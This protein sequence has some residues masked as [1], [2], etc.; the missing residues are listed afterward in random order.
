MAQTPPP[1]VTPAPGVP[2]RGTSTFKAL[3]DAFL[4]W[5]AM[6]VLQLSDL[7]LNVYNNAL[8][9]YNNAVA[10]AASAA[11]AAAIAGAT[12]WVS[13][14]PYASGVCKFS[15]LTFKT[16]RSRAAVTSAVDPSAD[17]ANWELL[18][19]GTL[20][21]LHVRNQQPSGSP[22]S[23]GS[24]IG[25]TQRTLNTVVA[26]TVTGASLASSNVTLP[27]G[28]YECRGITLGY[29]Q[30][31]HKGSLYNSTDGTTVVI[32]S[33]EY[34]PS[35]LTGHSVLVGRFTIAAAKTFQ[36]KHYCSQAGSGGIDD[37]TSGLAAVYSTLEFWKVG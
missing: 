15:P 19:Y 1:N 4:T 29:S 8:D 37:P 11:N 36:L 33:S 28:T 20:P 10:A 16:F 17:P 24:T 18:S 30:G 3:V 21:Y 12:V 32:G 26:N 23:D 35:G 2:V 9:C 13:G 25:T 7:A 14:T 22:A 31:Y 27:S 5:M 6:A 34:T